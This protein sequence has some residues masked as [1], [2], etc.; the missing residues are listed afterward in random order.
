M[1]KNIFIYVFCNSILALSHVVSAF[2]LLTLRAGIPDTDFRISK[3]AK[4][5]MLRL[6][7]KNAY[8]ENL[9]VYTN[10]ACKHT[11]GCMAIHMKILR[12]SPDTFKKS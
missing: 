2:S 10:T 8:D 1:N 9:I 3:V 5:F 4:Y 6:Q 7:F 11:G 12:T